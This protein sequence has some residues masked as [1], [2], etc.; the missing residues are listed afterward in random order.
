MC[1]MMRHDISHCRLR[2]Y[3]VGP[4]GDPIV[5]LANYTYFTDEKLEEM[6]GHARRDG[7]LKNATEEEMKWVRRKIA[8][9]K[10]EKK[11]LYKQN[12]ARFSRPNSP[13]RPAEAG[14]YGPTPSNL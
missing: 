9:L 12:A 4:D 3:N 13:Y 6:I 10:E 5:N 14:I 2:G 11:L 8:D 7:F 1:G